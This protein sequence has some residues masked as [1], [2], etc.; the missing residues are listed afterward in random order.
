[1]NFTLPRT[2]FA[3]GLPASLDWRN[4]DGLN[5]VTPV[6]DQGYCGSCVAFATVAT[7][8]TQYRI[9]TGFAGF[10]IKLSPQHLFSC[11]GGACSFGWFPEAA[12]R[13]LQHNGVPD[14]AC[15]PYTSGAT[16]QDVECSASCGNS[17]ARSV[18]IA[19]YTTPSRSAKD[20]DSVRMALQK[21]PLVTTLYVYADFEFYSSGIYKHV[22]GE[23]LGGHAVSIVGYN[24]VDRYFIIRNS[25]NTTW[26][27]AGFGNI[28][29]D[30]ISGVGDATWS[31]AMP[32]IA[33]AVTVEDPIDYTYA[34]ATL[35]V[36]AHSTYSNTDS[37]TVSFF[38]MNG[39]AVWSATC[40]AQDCAK[41]ADV[42]GFADGK[43]EVQAT[44]MD[45]NGQKLGD[46][47][48][49]FFYVANTKPTLS[50]SFTGTQGTNLDQPIK[51]TML[52]NVSAK[53]STVPMNAIE[54]H[55]V[56]PDGV[57]HVRAAQVVLDG[58]V[59]GW[60]T[61]FVANGNY[62]LYMTAHVKTNNG[63][64][65]VVESAHKTITI[66]N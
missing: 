55:R 46:S 30:D 3:D 44:A 62:D 60:T 50:L 31:Y 26:G 25:W 17:A 45:R 21:G 28:S 48:R 16:G 36:N 64:D 51:G 20:I 10:N 52:V 1:V 35:P 18:K 53:S 33:G 4:K 13:Y 6:L 22:T 23:G 63:T 42:S 58:M 59:M 54:F 7:L 12:S 15:M 11:G 2:H 56:G 19:S 29:Y 34:T 39:K 32:S 27:E 40:P 24:D 9:S 65:T 47:P 41:T 57:D 49:Q 38:N 14:E 61:T 5:W 8:E 66:A 43:Y 37:L